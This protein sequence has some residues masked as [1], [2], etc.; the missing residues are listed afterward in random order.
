MAENGA[1]RLPEIALFLTVSLLFSLSLSPSL[2][3]SLFLRAAAV[4]AGDGSETKLV[5]ATVGQ[6]S[7]TF[8]RQGAEIRP[9]PADGRYKNPHFAE[10]I[11]FF[12]K[13]SRATPPR[14][15]QRFRLSLH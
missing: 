8:V 1:F 9:R 4:D 14:P 7:P 12:F 11:N 5:V 15:R 3:E 6:K 10:I 2:W 13:S